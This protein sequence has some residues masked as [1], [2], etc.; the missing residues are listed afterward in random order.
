MSVT[1]FLTDV[2]TEMVVNLL[3]LFLAQVLGARTVAIGLI[4]GVAE[5]M[6]SLLKLFSG[7]LSDRLGSR[8][9]P[10]VLGYAFSTLA[11][12]GFALASTWIGVAAARWA[13]RVGKGVRTAPRDALVADSI[14]PRDRGLAF[15][16][17]RAAD[18]GGA[19]V[20]LLVAIA[21]VVATQRGV[22][23]LERSTFQTLVWVSLLPA[24]LAVA[25]LAFGATE[26]RRSGAAAST[27]L[28]LRGLGRP[29][30][31]FL[32]ISALFEL[33]NFSDAFLVLRAQERGL[34]V[35]G[36]LWMLVAF[37]AV[38]ALVST[39]AGALS[40]RIGRKGMLVSG[41]LLYGAVN[42]GFAAAGSAAHVVPLYLAYGVYYGLTAGAARAFVADLVPEALR[43]TAYGSYHAAMGLVALPASLLAGLLWEGI[44]AWA[45]FG[46]SAPFAFAAGTALLAAGLLA[47]GLRE[48]PSEAS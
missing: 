41:W 24:A 33:G 28:G 36:I 11:K 45:G 7:A 37:N 1:S 22:A 14:D 44:G 29:F 23:S 46:P 16:L 6:A 48:S 12:P 17:H 42:A 4:E 26:V 9:W 2:S 21:V 3:P 10:A 13:D 25:T 38:Y 19:V 15:G 8:K 47:V 5:S 39:P 18:T 34:G 32:G 35:V 40:D 43:G 20:G 27:R 30:A 31:L